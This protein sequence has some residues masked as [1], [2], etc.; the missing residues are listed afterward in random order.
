[1][2]IIE[3]FQSVL[4]FEDTSLQEKA[5]KVIPIVDLEFATMTRLGQ[6]HK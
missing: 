2:S 1:M 5:K 4:R 3:F 6:L